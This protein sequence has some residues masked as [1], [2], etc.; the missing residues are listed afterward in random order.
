VHKHTLH[1]KIALQG[2]INR[3][4]THYADAN[5][6]SALKLYLTCAKVKREIIYIKMKVGKLSTLLS[7]K[8]I[9]SLSE[10]VEKEE[11]E[12]EEQKEKEKEKER[13]EEEEKKAGDR[14]KEKA[15][16]E[17]KEQ[18]ICIRRGRISYSKSGSEGSGY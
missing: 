2:K 4:E 18:D 5:Y 7:K 13:E 10:S 17:E 6:F 9:V 14:G 1:S 11:E 12:M 3:Y 15:E 16:E 8:F